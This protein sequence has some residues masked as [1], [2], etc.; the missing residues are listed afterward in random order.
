M[1]IASVTL[2]TDEILA[3]LV[4]VDRVACVTFLVDD[5]KI[6]NVVGRY[7]PGI[8]RVRGKDVER[9]IG[10]NAD[11]VC[12]APYNAADFLEVLKR[13]GLATYRNEA[14]RSIDAIEMGIVALGARVGE[15]A[16]AD[17]IVGAMRSR[18]KR[19]ADRLTSVTTRPRVLYWSSGYTA[20][21]GST[22][23]DIIREAGG[24]NIA[25]ER[26]MN[27]S[28]EIEPEQVIGAEPDRILTT[29]W[30]DGDGSSAIENHP[31]LRSLQAVREK[32]VIAVEA[33]YLTTVSQ[34]IVEAEERLAR[35]LH[36]ELFGDESAP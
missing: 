13:S 34:F 33:K 27:L 31:L 1:R 18:R 15:T 20:G 32:R 30:A 28:A 4:P 12:V 8:P 36:P 17:K 16:Q 7:P 21:P 14:N 2:A 22:I 24:V 19:L 3:A 11:L 6:S 35:K 9:I 29:D 10:L 26:N 5:P 25:A 23:D